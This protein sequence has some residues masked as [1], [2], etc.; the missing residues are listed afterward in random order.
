MDVNILKSFAA[1][2]TTADWNI[3]FFFITVAPL[4][5]HRNRCSLIQWHYQI[6]SIHVWI[7]T[8]CIQI[9]WLNLLFSFEIDMV[10]YGFDIDSMLWSTNM[11]TVRSNLNSKPALRPLIV[12]VIFFFNNYYYFFFFSL[13]QFISHFVRRVSSTFHCSVFDVDVDAAVAVGISIFLSHSQ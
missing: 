12:I 1:P 11:L 7:C 8:L 2:T 4:I 5:E 13:I 9:I 3:L 6:L 10:R